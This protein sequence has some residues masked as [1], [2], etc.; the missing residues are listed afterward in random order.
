MVKA[1]KAE[2]ETLYTNERP[3]DYGHCKEIMQDKYGVE[4]GDKMYDD[5]IGMSGN[6]SAR[7]FVVATQILREKR[8]M[9]RRLNLHGEL[10]SKTYEELYD[11]WQANRSK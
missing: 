4:R 9:M 10:D 2:E 5:M 11:A 6:S 7:F 8:A 1:L 3:L